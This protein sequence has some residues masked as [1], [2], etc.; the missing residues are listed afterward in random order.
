MKDKLSYDLKIS[1]EKLKY[2]EMRLEQERKKTEMYSRC[3]HELECRKERLQEEMKQDMSSSSQDDR[4]E[5]QQ[6]RKRVKKLALKRGQKIEVTCT[7]ERYIVKVKQ[8]VDRLNE[9]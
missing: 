3:E 6:L 4:R 7:K 5:V 1:Q 8:M 2:L 9:L